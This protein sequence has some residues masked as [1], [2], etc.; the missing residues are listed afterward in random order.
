[1]LQQLY[2]KSSDFAAS[3]DLHS[4]QQWIFAAYA[5]APQLRHGG[6][7]QQGKTLLCVVLLPSCSC[8]L[9][10]PPVQL[11]VA[12]VFFAFSFS[13]HDQFYLS[14]GVLEGRCPRQSHLINSVKVLR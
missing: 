2:P 7:A 10:T 11:W 14:A 4:S 5:P 6:W 3:L 1:M 12:A 8:E 13:D 9:K